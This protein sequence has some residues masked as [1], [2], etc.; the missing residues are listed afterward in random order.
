[1][2][3]EKA[4]FFKLNRLKLSDQQLFETAISGFRPSACTCPACNA[5]GRLRQI[6]PYG[7]HMISI[8]DGQRADT[9]ISVPRFLCES[10][11]HSHALLPDFL[12]PFGSYSLRFVLS[13]LGGYLFR[14]GTV[15]DYCDHWQIAVS[16][17]YAWIH[18]FTSH[19]NAWCSILDRISWASIVALDTVSSCSAF[20]SAFFLRF[21]FSF[22]QARGATPSGMPPLCDRR[23]KGCRT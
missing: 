20:P 16:T 1:M 13:V 6:R 5:E 8:V 7:R 23:Q 2:I 12:I 22:L 14:T 11:G 10:C 19:Y 4:I 15:A 17:L 9:L 21:G 18:L 3:R